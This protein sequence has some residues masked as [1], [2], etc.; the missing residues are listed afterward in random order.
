MVSCKLPEL[1]ARALSLPGSWC[2]G[3]CICQNTRM[4]LEKT[5]VVSVVHF[6]LYVGFRSDQSYAKSALPIEPCR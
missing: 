4:G 2:V 6:H 1:S 3:G 5:F